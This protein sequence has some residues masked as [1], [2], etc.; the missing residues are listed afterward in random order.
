M[1]Y[2]PK[3]NTLAGITKTRF[4]KTLG[5]GYV[6]EIKPGFDLKSFVILAIG[7]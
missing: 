6:F 7:F 3:I 2:L 1:M 4:S 5:L